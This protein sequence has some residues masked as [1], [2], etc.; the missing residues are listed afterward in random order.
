VLGNAE[1]VSLEGKFDT[2]V[3]SYL[4]KY[5]DLNRLLGNVAHHI[6]PGGTFI[7]HDFRL[8]TNRLYRLAWQ[9]YSRAINSVGGA[10]LPRWRTV[11]DGGLTNLIRESRWFDLLPEALSEYGFVDVQKKLLSFECAVLVWARK[12]S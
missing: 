7:A 9:H 1:T 10:L 3:S 5:V 8:P 4:A 6:K 2:V 11:F 12:E